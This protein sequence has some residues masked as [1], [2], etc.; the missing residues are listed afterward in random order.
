MISD[1]TALIKL[2]K[3]VILFS[4]GVILFLLGCVVYGIILNLREKSLYEEMELK[5]LKELNNVHLVVYRS[6]NEVNLF[7]DTVLVKKYRA[8]FGRNSQ[9]KSKVND[10]ATPVGEY[11]ICRI[12]SNHIYHRF[13]KLNYPNLEDAT[14][15]LRKKIVSQKEFDRLKFDYYYGECINDTT[16]LGGNI[17]IHGIGQ[18]DYVFKHLPFVFNWTNGSIAVSNENVDE[19][20]SVIKNGTKVIIKM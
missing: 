8:V 15:G 16:A 10:R 2:L 5:N 11:R 9:P 4:G 6:R 18:L 7:S 13:L 19:I 14:E 12:D 17:G 1:K 3:N 20:L